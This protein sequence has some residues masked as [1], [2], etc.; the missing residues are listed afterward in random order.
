MAT[1]APIPK[2][3]GVRRT[4]RWEITDEAA[5]L[6]A[7][8]QVFEPSQVRINALIKTLRD[9]DTVPGLRIWTETKASIR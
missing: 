4:T 9:G 6:A 1:A 5:L 7:C 8:P 2:G 3:A